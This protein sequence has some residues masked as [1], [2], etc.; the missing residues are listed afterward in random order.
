VKLTLNALKPM[1]EH[2]T[3]GISRKAETPGFA[4]HYYSAT[5]LRS[6]GTVTVGGRSVEVTGESWFDHEWAT[7]QLAPEQRGWDWFSLQLADGSELMLYQLRRRDGTT[8]PASSGTWITAD[9]KTRHLTREEIRLTPRHWWTS[10]KT[11]G[12]YPIGWQIEVPALALQLEVS[13]P[14]PAQ[15]LAL[16]PVCYWE[17]VIDVCGTRAGQP[18]TGHGY[19]ELTGYAGEIVGLSTEPPK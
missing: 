9:G 6:Q 13:T 11:G 19:L 17:G 4:S 16:L 5:R 7:N 12:K 3:D 18:V 2:G 8:D 14:V 15:E 1:V 10:S